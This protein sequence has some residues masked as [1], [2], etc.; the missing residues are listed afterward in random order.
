VASL[1]FER[2]GADLELGGFPFGHVILVEESLKQDAQF[3]GTI[4]A[5]E[6]LSERCT[7]AISRSSPLASPLV[8]TRHRAGA[9]MTLRSR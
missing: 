1:L 5:V 7:W 9:P 3:A 2:S 6:A 4:G 8:R